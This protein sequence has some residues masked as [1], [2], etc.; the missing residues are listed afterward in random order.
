MD[1]NS[2]QELGTLNCAAL[3]VKSSP[4]AAEGTSFLTASSDA[5]IETTGIHGITIS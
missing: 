3:L 5:E 1:G 4:S 2:V